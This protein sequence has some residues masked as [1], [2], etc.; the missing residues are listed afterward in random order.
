MHTTLAIVSIPPTMKALELRGYGG[1]N[2]LALASRPTPR[3]GRGEVLVRMAAAP[4]NPSDLLFLRGR[5]GI[6]KTLP[7]IP[8]FEGSGLVVAAGEGVYARALLGR[9]VACAASS[10]DGTWAEY[11]VTRASACLPLLPHVSYMGGAMLIVNPLSAI[12]LLDIARRGGHRAVVHTAAASALGRALVRLAQ[13]RGPVLV[14]IVRRAEQVAILRDLGATYI[15][16]SSG[17]DFDRQLAETCAALHVTLA[18]DAIAG[19]T[20]GR[21]LRAMPPGGRVLVYG[22]L[23][24]E[25]CQI[26]PSEFIFRRQQAGG[27]WLSDWIARQ[28]FLKIVLLGLRLQTSLFKAVDTVIQARIPLERAHEGLAQYEQQMSKGKVLLVP[29]VRG[30]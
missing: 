9:R 29:F 21:L 26:D 20:T 17:P 4:I 10:G 3:P 25:A 7:T 16:D 1:M 8:G 2:D 15:L 28:S 19:E 13:P 12:A 14:N 18:F 23:S 11:M 30:L 5:Y 22:A 6:R 27:F 24:E